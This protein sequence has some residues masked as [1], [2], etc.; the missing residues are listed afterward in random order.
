MTRRDV[1][2]LGVTASALVVLPSVGST[3]DRQ[4]RYLIGVAGMT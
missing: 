1:L 2:M 3:E 4:R